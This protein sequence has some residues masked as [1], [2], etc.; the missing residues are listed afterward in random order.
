M[1][2]N[3]TIPITIIPDRL[4]FLSTDENF[5]PSN[6]ETN[7]Y[8]F[9]TTDSELIYKSFFADFGPLDLGLTYIF[10]DR[11]KQLF[12][13][14]NKPIVYYCSDHFHK[15][16]NSAVLLCA[17]LIFVLK[18]SPQKAYKPFLRLS[19]PF[20]PFRDAAFCINTYPLTVLDCVLAMYKAKS[21]GHFDFNTF[22]LSNFQKLNKL[23]NGDIS[24]IIPNKFIAFSGPLRERREISPGVFALQPEEYVPIFKRLGV[25][26]IVRFNKK[27]YDRDVFTS[28]GIKHCELYYED[29]ANPTEAILQSFLQLCEK[30]EGVIAVHC[31]A[32]LGR[33]GTNIA[34]Y[35]IKHYGYTARESIAWCRL[36]RP[37]SIVGPQ[38]QYL[39][40]VEDKLKFEGDM[41]RRDVVDNRARAL[42]TRQSR[43]GPPVTSPNPSRPPLTSPN[44]IKVMASNKVT[45]TDTEETVSISTPS[46]SFRGVVVPPI[47]MSTNTNDNS[48][49]SNS[50]QANT[51]RPGIFRS[52]LQTGGTRSS[53][54]SSQSD[55]AVDV[56]NTSTGHSTARTS[57]SISDAI[58]HG[59]ASLN[60]KGISPTRSNRP[61]SQS[62]DLSL[63]SKASRESQSMKSD[64]S[65]TSSRVSYP[66]PHSTIS[67]PVTYREVSIESSQSSEKIKSNRSNYSISSLFNSSSPKSPANYKNNYVIPENTETDSSI[68]STEIS[69][70]SKKS[71]Y[72][73]WHQSDDDKASSTNS[74]TKSIKFPNWHNNEEKPDMPP[75]TTRDRPRTSQTHSTKL[76]HKA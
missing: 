61:H 10:C 46:S 2:I 75:I 59:L 47:A 50:P 49:R 56:V 16:S 64:S 41:Y 66:N 25:T 73:L 52:V 45:P 39:L 9:I 43:P 31:K 42:D 26:C 17:F 54:P 40:S 34:A 23:E 12:E 30:T 24:W 37:G 51:W 28:A 60:L 32:G 70:K 29:G 35:M 1:E 14:S 5:R 7:K 11:I 58:T 71:N 57:T 19:K 8:N 21:L 27:E 63:N 6:H 15:K 44:L 67:A 36:C 48:N 18:F 65:V 20:V 76:S 62:E 55:S 22:S 74:S 13:S 33:T 53:T 68:I 38:Q 72:P 3:G 4:Y 69:S